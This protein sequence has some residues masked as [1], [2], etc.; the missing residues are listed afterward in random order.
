MTFIVNIYSDNDLEE[1]IYIFFSFIPILQAFPS[2]VITFLHIGIF[3]CSK[4]VFTVC[5]Y[6][7]VFNY[8]TEI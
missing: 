1:N 6:S 2:S 4:F 7:L 5:L 3:I 8:H